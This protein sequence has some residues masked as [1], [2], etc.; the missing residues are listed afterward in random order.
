MQ[1]NC[2][3]YYTSDLEACSF[4]A[5]DQIELSSIINSEIPLRDKFW[6][7]CKKINTK[8]QNQK[9]AI[10]VAEIVLPIHENRYPEDMRVR[11]CIEAAK[12]YITRYI[13]L[14]KLIEKRRAAAAAD[15][16][17]AAA[18]AFKQ[19]LFDYLA[20]HCKQFEK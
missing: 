16:T 12:Q 7:V 10:D 5:S 17:Y 1:D 15:A 9:L 4:M 2:G 19:Q 13:S 6:F 11:E 20:E 3:C 8:E 14:E 18:D